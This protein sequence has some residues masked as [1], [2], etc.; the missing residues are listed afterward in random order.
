MPRIGAVRLI[1]KFGVVLIAAM[2][3]AACA[4][5]HPKPL[6]LRPNAIHRV[7]DVVVDAS[8]L[9][10]P[11]LAAHRFDPSDGLDMT[12]VAML[13]VVNN[14][15]LKL[16]RDDANV[17][18]AQ[19]FEAGLLPDPQLNVAEDVPAPR[20]PGA[21]TAFNL[22]LSL[23]TRALLLRSSREKA[24][25]AAS[26]QVNLALLW[27]EWQVVSQ[28]R[29]LFARTRMLE[30]L[31]PILAAERRLLAAKYA[32]SQRALAAGDT[33][34]DVVSADLSGLQSVDTQI[35]A[36]ERETIKTRQEL[37]A[38]LGLAP[39]VRLR[40]VGRSTLPPLYDNQIRADLA[41]LAAYRPDLLAL[42]AGYASQ[43]YQLRAAILGQFPAVGFS[44]SRARDTSNVYTLGY[45]LTLSLPFFN[46]SRGKIAVARATRRRLYDEF[47]VR[48]N[49]ADAQVRRIM[50]DRGLM[51]AQL[52]NVQSGVASLEQT[53]SEAS[54]AF[55]AGDINE[56]AYVDLRKSLLTKRIEAARLQEGILEQEIALAMLVGSSP[57]SLHGGGK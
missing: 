6:S 2:S 10:F 34:I 20:S 28:A 51:V 25:N 12:E 8:R 54:A 4:V 9:P 17:S 11:A 31:S 21:T 32:H 37:D 23:N 16:A 29:L 45:G 3:M 24:A 41:R 55:R 40:L 35:N 30:K 44:F 47:E 27:K 46:G 48:L 22:G 14:P 15:Q 53:V 57:F 38:L 18:R 52:A 33:T 43:D 36:L 5:Y 26:R 39:D 7:R 13:A 19:A 1:T 50:A 49:Q 56:L 42:R